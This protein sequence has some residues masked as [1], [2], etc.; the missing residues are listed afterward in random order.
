MMKYIDSS[1]FLEMSRSRNCGSFEGN[2]ACIEHWP[3]K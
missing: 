3:E 2:I 1:N